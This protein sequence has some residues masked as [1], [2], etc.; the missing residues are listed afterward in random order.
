MG[1]LKS[2]VS[3]YKEKNSVPN[4]NVQVNRQTNNEQVNSIYPVVQDLVLL[5]VCE[6]FKTIETKYPDYLRTEYEIGFPNEKLKALEKSGKIRPSNNVESLYHL[7]ATE[8]KGIA[9]QYGLKASGKKEKLCE[10]IKE[11]VP[12][13]ALD[14]Y[15]KNRYW[16]LTENGKSFLKQFSFIEYFTGKHEYSLNVAGIKINAIFDIFNKHPNMPVRDIIWGECNRKSL[17]YYQLG[18]SKGE[19]RNY[20]E[21]LRTM[22]LFLKEENRWQDSLYLY[23]RYMHYHINF[24]SSLKAMQ[25]YSVLKDKNGTTENL[26]INSEILPFTANEIMSISNGC[27]FDSN[28]LQK[29][30]FDALLKEKDE[31]IFTAKQLTD[32]IM[33]GLNGNKEG[34]MQ[35]CRAAVNTMI[36]NSPKR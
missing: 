11:Q 3:K 18:M 27:G 20:C 35:I 30:I 21:L 23:T 10:I 12:E 33:F 28:Q 29:F 5:S 16:V 25:Y 4:P 24:E 13:Q 36:K 1:F 2:V 8:L 26:F 9:T 7:K 19:F 17:E 15:I 6:S 22:A 31:G 32:F 14:Q 34:Q